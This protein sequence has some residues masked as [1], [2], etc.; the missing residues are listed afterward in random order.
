M[1]PP[2]LGQLSNVMCIINVADLMIYDFVS[3]FYGIVRD[4]FWSSIQ[5]TIALNMAADGTSSILMTS[6]GDGSAVE[7]KENTELERIKKEC[8]GMITTLKAL[9]DEE[10]R[11]REGNQILAQQAVIMGCTAGLDAAA[12]RM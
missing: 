9:H 1:L 6:G 11:L 10:K 5:S 3:W 12:R 2:E 8:T 4:L 7:T